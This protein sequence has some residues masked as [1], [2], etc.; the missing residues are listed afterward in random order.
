MRDIDQLGAVLDALV[1]AGATNIDGPSF[2]IAEPERC[3]ARRATL[4]SPMRWPGQTLR[5]AVGVEL[6]EILRSRKPVPFATARLMMRAEAMAA[7]VPIAPGRPAFRERHGGVRDQI[8]PG[9]RT[10]A[11]DERLPGATSPGSSI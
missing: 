9:P 2:D 3:W 8:G 7:D 11:G 1:S 4:R 10:R 6:G 5:R